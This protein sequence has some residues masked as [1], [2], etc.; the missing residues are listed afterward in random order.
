[1][2]RINPR[3]ELWKTQLEIRLSRMQESR[4]KAGGAT[5]QEGTKC[6]QG[7]A[8]KSLLGMDR[9]GKEYKIW[10]VVT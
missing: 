5:G 1:M 10:I 4:G 7:P 3:Q 6:S 9:A 8:A 2:C